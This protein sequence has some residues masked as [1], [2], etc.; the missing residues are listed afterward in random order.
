MFFSVA[1]RCIVPKAAQYKA[2]PYDS[3]AYGEDA[4]EIFWSH[5]LSSH[6]LGY[7]CQSISYFDRSDLDEIGM[8]KRTASLTNCRRGKR[9]KQFRL[10][11][12]NPKEPG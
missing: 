1:H 9:R 11:V 8:A 5:R 12:E 3:S 6:F 7:S 4:F 2:F 10:S